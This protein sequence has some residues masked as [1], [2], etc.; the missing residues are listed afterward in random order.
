VFRK[1][2]TG[3]A[4]SVAEARMTP[5]ALEAECTDQGFK[6]AALAKCVK[7]KTA[8]DGGKIYRASANC[9]AGT[10]SPIDE[11]KYTFAGV[12][13]N[14]DI[15]G[16]RTKWRDVST[17]EVVGRDNASGGLSLSQQWEVLCPGPL[18]IVKP[19]Q[20]ARPAT[21]V[22]PPVCS[23]A[24]NCTEVN[25]FAATITDF[26][27]STAGGY[28]LV[29]G[30]IRFQNKL[31]RPLILGYLSGSGLALDDRGNRFQMNEN[32]GLRGMGFVRANQVDP[33]F[34][35]GPGQTAD[36]RVEYTWYPRGNEIFGTQYELD[37]AV[38]EIVPVSASQFRV[39]LEHP[40]KWRGLGQPEVSAAPAAVTASSAPAADAAVVVPAAV[41]HCQGLARCYSAGPFT[42]QIMQ[43]TLSMAHAG[44]QALNFN[45]RF[46]NVTAQPLVLAYKSG[47]SVAIDNHGQRYG[48]RGANFARGIGV[49]GGGQVNADFVIQPGQTRDA[50]FEVQRY[51]GRTLVGTG[52][53][54]DVAVDQ[55][56]LLPA[57]QVRALREYSLNFPDLTASNP[58]GAVASPSGQQLNEA[59][60]KL[61]DIFRRRR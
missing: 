8:E 40:L 26:R 15:G 42:A 49:S 27:T 28:R 10:L 11:K 7:E 18:R 51:L 59:A 35:L 45:V 16:G 24:P 56:E 38:R 41:D 33:K 17:G 52:F 30:T 61:K 34:I 46:R 25:S 13:S 47:T 54:W 2:G 29:T 4:I 6:G 48:Q 21:P 19:A 55:L 12:W 22:P 44:Y 1:T 5:A 36:A 31:A 60:Q 37:F 58:V 9:M 39:G 14:E 23:G 20:V 3:T 32:T 50:S 43:V 57:N 53:T